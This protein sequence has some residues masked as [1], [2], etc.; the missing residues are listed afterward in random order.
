MTIND[1]R[2]TRGRTRWLLLQWLVKRFST[3]LYIQA[4]GVI[5]TSWALDLPSLVS[6]VIVEI[7]S[8]LILY[9]IFKGKLTPDVALIGLAGYVGFAIYVTHI[10]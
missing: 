3:Q 9:H 6:V 5:V 10:L 4:S 8:L 1:H 7:V 2:G